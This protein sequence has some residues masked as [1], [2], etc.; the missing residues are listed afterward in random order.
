MKFLSFSKRYVFILVLLII[1]GFCF[2]SF[3]RSAQTPRE[4]NGNFAKIRASET[5][6]LIIYTR[7]GCSACD[8]ALKY[9]QLH[10]IPYHEREITASEK[11]WHEFVS[12]K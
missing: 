12:F 7:V 2:G 4:I 6:R 3:I 5:E 1:G 11:N 9:F 10:S 8:E